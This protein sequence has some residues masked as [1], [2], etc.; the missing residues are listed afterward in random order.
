VRTA[1][2]VAAD[3]VREDSEELAPAP[4]GSDLTIPVQAASVRA[5]PAGSGPAI[6]A[7]LVPVAGPRDLVARAMRSC[8]G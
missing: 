8:R 2:S 4:M 6:P 1:R 3:P 5:D 7:A